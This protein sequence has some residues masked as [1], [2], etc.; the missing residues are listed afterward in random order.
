[1][2]TKYEIVQQNKGNLVIYTR[3]TS[4][5]QPEGYRVHRNNQVLKDKC[6]RA[7]YQVIRVYSEPSSESPYKVRP[8]LKQMLKDAASGLFGVVVVWDLFT[9]SPDGE[10]L[11]QIER[12]LAE[13]DVELCS[14]TEY[15]DTSTEEGVKVFEYMC[16]LL[17]TKHLSLSALQGIPL[18]QV[19]RWLIED[20]NKK[21]GENDAK[22]CAT[23][24]RPA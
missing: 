18:S 13:Y 22:P 2:I 6:E 4:W 19:A 10:E 9:L 8:V 3:N 14:A 20:D 23:A 1:M 24:K 15:F 16:K 17:N 21:G 7:G 11:Q 5:T 12:E